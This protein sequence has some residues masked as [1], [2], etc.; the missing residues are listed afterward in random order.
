MKTEIHCFYC[1]TSH[2][3]NHTPLLHFVGW[4][5]KPHYGFSRGIWILSWCLYPAYSHFL[6][7]TV[8][9]SQRKNE[10][11]EERK[12]KWMVKMGTKWRTW[13]KG[14]E[15]IQI[16]FSNHLS[17]VF[18][19]VPISIVYLP[20]NIIVLPERIQTSFVQATPS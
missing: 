15:R 20:I 6:N 9:H 12:D 11:A 4:N 14:R 7:P 16:L 3:S 19:A 1:T 13:G 5:C 18:H 10:V 17:Y 2:A 8:I